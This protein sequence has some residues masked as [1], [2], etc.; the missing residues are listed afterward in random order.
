M[1][2]LNFT[3]L[4]L[5]SEKVTAES[6]S[7]SLINWGI[8]SLLVTHKEVSQSLVTANPPGYLSCMYSWIQ[9]ILKPLAFGI[10]PALLAMSA[11][12]LFVLSRQN[13]W[14][15]QSRAEHKRN[16]KRRKGRSKIS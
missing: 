16:Q 2:P 8:L 7:Q 4:S 1:T 12:T 13:P 5:T 3:D 14:P 6:N 11:M 10:I 15:R 9:E